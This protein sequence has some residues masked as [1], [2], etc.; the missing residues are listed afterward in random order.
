MH[1][2]AALS[3]GAAA[4]IV[5]ADQAATAAAGAAT[6][7]VGAATAAARP[8]A[9]TD[10][11]AEEVE[12]GVV[13][14]AP[15]GDDRTSKPPQKRKSP[16][17]AAAGLLEKMDT[18]AQEKAKLKKQE[19]EKAKAKEAE[20]LGKKGSPASS[21]VPPSALRS[22]PSMPKPGQTV[23]YLGAKVI[24]K[25]TQSKFRVFVPANV[26]SEWGLP[27]AVDIDRQWGADPKAV[28]KSC[29]EKIYELAHI[30]R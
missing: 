12:E 21:A 18:K 3:A 4:P 19:K 9:L 6:A 13:A 27:K 26:A 7:A 2:A 8:L 17:D 25:P 14:D 10:G 30:K 11:R 22:A 29:L 23:E 24:S 20:K 1:A 15:A 16:E 5:L 28:F